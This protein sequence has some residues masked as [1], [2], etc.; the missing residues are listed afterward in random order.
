MNNVQAERLKRGLS[1]AE[2][3]TRA[4]VA[5]TTIRRIEDPC[6]TSKV[7]IDTARQLAAFLNTTVRDLFPDGEELTTLGG[8]SVRTNVPEPRHY[9]ACANCHMEIPPAF[10]ECPECN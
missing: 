10:K 5:K 1:V 8:G 4:D 3:S 2:F 7:H 6:D 9:P